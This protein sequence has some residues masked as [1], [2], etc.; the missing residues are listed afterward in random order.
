MRLRLTQP[1]IVAFA[2]TLILLSAAIGWF[3]AK[4]MPRSNATTPVMAPTQVLAPA[5]GGSGVYDHPSKCYD[6][7][8]NYA[9]QNDAWQGQK[10]KCFSCE[11]D[12]HLNTPFDA[13]P[14]RYY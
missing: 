9:D 11:T 13:H 2:A 4:S 1:L 7:E 12:P 3:L 14:I 10:S 5:R 8:A 6:C